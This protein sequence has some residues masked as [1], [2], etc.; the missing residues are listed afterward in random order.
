MTRQKK[1]RKKHK[2]FFHELFSLNFCF[3]LLAWLGEMKRSF[4]INKINLQVTFLKRP[5]TKQ[6]PFSALS[7]KLKFINPSFLLIFKEKKYAFK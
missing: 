4:T 5:Y 2:T 7:I 3:D 6:L 1:E